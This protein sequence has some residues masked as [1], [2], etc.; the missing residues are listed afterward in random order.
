[1][2]KGIWSWSIPCAIADLVVFVY[3]ITILCEAWDTN[4]YCM[5]CFFALVIAWIK[6]LTSIWRAIA[7]ENRGEEEEEDEDGE[8]DR[9]YPETENNL[10][11]PDKGGDSLE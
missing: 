5:A 11:F 7:H 3:T 4:R 9:Y 6:F 1:M 10:S 2:S 8:D